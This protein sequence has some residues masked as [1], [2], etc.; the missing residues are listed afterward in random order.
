MNTNLKNIIGHYAIGSTEYWKCK[1]S[2]IIQNIYNM[3]D[4]ENES[5]TDTE[6]DTDETEP[7]TELEMYEN[8]HA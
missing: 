5:D 4:V 3:E 1:F 7:E 2:K 8:K 6:Y